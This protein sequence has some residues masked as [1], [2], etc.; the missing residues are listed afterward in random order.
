LGPFAELT[1]K[2]EGNNESGI[3]KLKSMFGPTINSNLDL[4]TNE[5]TFKNHQF[6]EADEDVEPEARRK[7]KINTPINTFGPLDSIKSDLYKALE[8]IL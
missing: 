3:F 8:K 2:L 5:D 7:I 4:E 1:E 6:E